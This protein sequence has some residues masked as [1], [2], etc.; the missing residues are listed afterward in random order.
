MVFQDPYRSLNPRRSVLESMIEGPMNFGVSRA[1]AIEKARELMD[2]VRLPEAGLSRYP[3]EFSGGQRQRI[4]IARALAC[5]P[6][7][8]IADEAVSALDVSVQKQILD[9]LEDIQDQFGLAMLFITHDL[10]VAARLCDRILVMQSGRV[11]E[12]GTAQ[13]VLQAPRQ[14]YTQQL[15]AAIP[16]KELREERI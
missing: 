1:T 3:H 7:L 13:Q 12:E 8:L 2:R 4:C 15:I 16:Q 5:E 10:R 9:L 6:R 11:V 14:P